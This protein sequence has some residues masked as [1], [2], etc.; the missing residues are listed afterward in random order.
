M[1]NKV[2]CIDDDANI[3]TGI[4]RNLRK[5]FDLDTAVGALA[6]L[7]MIENECPYA[8]IVADM[9]MPSMNGVEF[10]NIVRQKYPDTVRVMLTGNADQKTATD[11]VNKGQIFQFLNKPCPPERLAEV[12]T[13]GIKHYRLITAERELLENTLNGSVKVLMEILSLS[14][15]ASFGRGQAVRDQARQVAQLLQL[16]STWEIDLAAMLCPIG[17][18]SLPAELNQKVHAEL[19][20]TGAEKDAVARVPQVGHDLLSKIPRLEAVARIVLYQNKN[21]DGTGFPSDAVKGEEI[22]LEARI[23]RA[24]TDLA[25]LEARKIPRFKALEQLRQR[26]GNYDSRVLDAVATCFEL[27]TGNQPEAAVKSPVAL[28]FSELR[29]GHVLSANIVT[30]QDILIVGAGTKITPLILE[31]LR[32][33]AS[34]SGLKLP[35]HVEG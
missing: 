18:V 9:Q 17:C 28:D 16:K 15:P 32:N 7:K 35:I 23:L 3:L 26:H 6:A 31:R 33:F 30:K 19:D 8:V 24:L 5:Q 25:K 22:P 29:A 12:L 14:D 10:L 27:T 34:L 11:A 21:F 13:G 4:Q 20:L 2:L 1:N